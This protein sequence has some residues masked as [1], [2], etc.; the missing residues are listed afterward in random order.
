MDTRSAVH[1]T[2]AHLV[3]LT[4][5]GVCALGVSTA[6]ASAAALALTYRVLDDS[7]REGRQVPVHCAATNDRTSTVPSHCFARVEGPVR[8]R[9]PVFH[10]NRH[11]V[12]ALAPTFS[13]AFRNY[14]CSYADMFTD[15]VTVHLFVPHRW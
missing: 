6:D 15:E 12:N 7:V 2:S 9:L 13:R 5:P 1:D 11:S 3:E 4:T 8:E 10:H 14:Q